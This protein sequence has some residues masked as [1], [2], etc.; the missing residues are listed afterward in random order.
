[1]RTLALGMMMLVVDVYGLG[2]TPAGGRPDALNALNE[3]F[4]PTYQARAARLGETHPAYVEVAGDS[5][6]LHL[7]GQQ[8]LKAQVLDERYQHLKDIAHVPFTI[9]LTL[10]GRK[11]G[12]LPEADLASMRGLLEKVNA[13]EGGLASAGF[14]EE[15]VPRQREILG[16]SRRLLEGTLAGREMD[17]AAFAKAMGPLLMKNA[18][19]AGCEQVR[20]THA[21]M[22]RW[23]ALMSREEWET[24][25]VVNK[26]PHQPRYR[27]VDTQY[28][29]WLLGGDTTAWAYAGESSRVIYAETVFGPQDAGTELLSVLVDFEAGKAF[30]G[31]KWRLSEDV[32]SDGAERCVKGLDVRDRDWKR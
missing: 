27:N 5:L 31:D 6:L 29:G 26:S 21:Q 15:E 22:M 4:V 30:F 24:F 8:A 11:A 18:D 3:S 20:T 13:A 10:A 2:Q 19:E 9:Y 7:H 32:L 14:A 23:K 1:M 28:F 17:V 12:S 25:A 16:A